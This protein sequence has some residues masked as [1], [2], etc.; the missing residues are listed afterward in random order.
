MGRGLLITGWKA[1][2]VGDDSGTG[3]KSAR[4]RQESQHSRHYL[5]IK[6]RV[7]KDGEAGKSHSA[8]G[9][10]HGKSTG[11]ILLI[12]IEDLNKMTSVWTL[13]SI[14]LIHH[15]TDSNGCCT[16]KSGVSPGDC[17]DSVLPRVVARGG[18]VAYYSLSNRLRR[19]QPSPHPCAG[20]TI[21]SALIAAAKLP[22]TCC[23]LGTYGTYVVVRYLGNLASLKPGL[24]LTAPVSDT[25]LPEGSMDGPPAT[26]PIPLPPLQPASDHPSRATSHVI[27]PTSPQTSFPLLACFLSQ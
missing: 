27:L 13:Q 5:G 12:E 21:K 16:L 19:P 17:P 20:H 8:F 1:H 14:N 23:N 3:C 4:P 11:Y 6:P 22:L 25:T 2:H 26:T 24:V 15:A 18:D 7:K 9:G 10:T